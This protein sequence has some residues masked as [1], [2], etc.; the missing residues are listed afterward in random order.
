MTTFGW[1]RFKNL[2]YLARLFV[3]RSS[4]AFKPAIY[5]YFMNASNY[6]KPEEYPSKSRD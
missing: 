4:F 6:T 2:L 5:T 3:Q 1:L